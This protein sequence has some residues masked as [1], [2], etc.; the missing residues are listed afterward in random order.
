MALETPSGIGAERMP[1]GGGIGDLVQTGASILANG[2]D[3]FLPSD[4]GYYNQGLDHESILAQGEGDARSAEAIAR[5]EDRRAA[6]M[7]A[8]E[9]ALG[10]MRSEAAN[11]NAA[12]SYKA[13]VENERRR[14]EAAKKAI[15]LLR[16]RLNPYADAGV[17]GINQKRELSAMSTEALKSMDSLGSSNELISRLSRVGSGG[18]NSPLLDKL[19][20]M[21]S[22]GGGNSPL[23]DKLRGM[24]SGG[25]DDIIERLRG[26]GSGGE[27]S[28]SSSKFYSFNRK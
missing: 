10:R 15:G 1:T 20:G 6:A 18:G 12:A 16:K 8:Y 26:L 24:T 27:D 14:K 25:S 23:L 21:T 2:L 3:R 22:S 13:A 28:S 17:Q 5:Y 11:A 19:R 7:T 4:G 9:N